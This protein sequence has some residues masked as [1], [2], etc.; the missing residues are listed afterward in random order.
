MVPDSSKI[1]SDSVGSFSCR[2]G[3]AAV[4][5]VAAVVVGGRNNFVVVLGI[6]FWVFRFDQ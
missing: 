4:A 5:G 1:L 2:F 3:L 6:Q